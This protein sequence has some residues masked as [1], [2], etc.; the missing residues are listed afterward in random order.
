MHLH[1]QVAE[2]SGCEMDEWDAAK[3]SECKKA[4]RVL[5]GTPEVFRVSL[6]DRRFLSVC[7]ISLCVFD[8][9]HNA[10][11]NSPMANIM[12]DGISVAGRLGS[13]C[14]QG[15]ERSGP[16]H[17]SQGLNDSPTDETAEPP[18]TSTCTSCLRSLTLSPKTLNPKPEALNP[19][20]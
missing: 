10:V 2:L 18:A 5:V 7:D 6:V 9:C 19:K 4:Y 13:C 17:P 16:P 8:E 3:W 15:A 11:G 14:S 12:R 20:P 1:L